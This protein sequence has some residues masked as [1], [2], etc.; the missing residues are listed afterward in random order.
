MPVVFTG[1]RVLLHPELGEGL[2]DGC[3][4]VIGDPDSIFNDSGSLNTLRGT[5]VGETTPEHR[6]CHWSV[7]GFIE[8][9][10]ANTI[11][12][13]GVKQSFQARTQEL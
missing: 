2:D 9:E 3:R 11:L 7:E 5:A 6:Q 8:E 12:V 1:W 4:V 10:A 13:P